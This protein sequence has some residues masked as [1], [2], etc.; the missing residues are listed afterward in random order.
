MIFLLFLFRDSIN[1]TLASNSYQLRTLPEDL[2]QFLLGDCLEFNHQRKKRDT[3]N[4]ETTEVSV[5][6]IEDDQSDLSRTNKRT[7]NRRRGSRNRSLNKRRRE[8]GSKPFDTTTSRPSTTVA[9]NEIVDKYDKWNRQNVSRNKTSTN[10]ELERESEEADDYG[11][12]NR[13][14]GCR[15]ETSTNDELEHE[16]EESFDRNVTTTEPSTTPG[17]DGLPIIFPG[18]ENK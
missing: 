18:E 14:R 6:D 10:S 15:N 16:S 12:C 7:S 3:D 2:M 9:L 4:I 13:Q 11:E 1:R 8:Q 5:D 17:Y